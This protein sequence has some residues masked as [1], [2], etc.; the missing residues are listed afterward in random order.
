MRGGAG[1][2]GGY[3]I[4]YNNFQK[5]ISVHNLNEKNLHVNENT[6]SFNVASY[7]YTGQNFGKSET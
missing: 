2:A 6:N 5:W 3:I 7:N 1:E 4:G